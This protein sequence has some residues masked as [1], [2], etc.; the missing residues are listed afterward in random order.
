M[1][2]TNATRRS[3]HSIGS[4]AAAVA[5]GQLLSF[6]YPLVS[7]PLLARA[8][9]ADTLGRLIVIFAALQLLVRLTDYGFSVSAVRS[10]SLA[11]SEEERARTIS[12]TLAASVML[13]VAG[14]GT[15]SLVLLLTPSLRADFWLYFIG[16]VTISIGLGFPTWLLQGLRRLKLFALL[17]AGSRILALGGLVV[18]LH[19]PGDLAWAVLWQFAPM[20]IAALI[21]WPYL[22]TKVI[23]PV[24]PSLR[25]VWR[26]LADGRYPFYSSIA[27][28][29]MGSV[30]ALL[31]GIL[32]TPT[33][34]AYYGAGERFGN[35]GRGVLWAVSDAM[36]PRMADAATSQDESSRNQRRVIMGGLFLV[37]AMGGTTLI[38]VA[39]WFVPW[40]LG[41]GFESTVPVAR[42]IGVSLIVSGA[43]AVLALALNAEHRYT[44]T[45]KAIT[46]GAACHIVLLLF[47]TPQFGANGAAW[48]LVAS[49]L[50]VVLLLALPLW[51]RPRKS[52]HPNPSTTPRIGTAHA[53]YPQEA[54]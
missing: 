42:L 43:V 31:L 9:G 20:G 47:L 5:A 26:T 29:V 28:G 22:I 21:V 6:A 3:V 44:A 36:I 39:S 8:L 48:A 34:V 1:R 45:A 53:D 13:W 50:I 12:A 18:T 35:A 41:P 37:F 38:I 16:F 46:A 33:Q 19:G 17:T 11:S 54:A 24:V 49:E 52:T 7:L 51:R 4:D 25:L 40:Y 27:Q 2:L 23:R 15:T 32:S 30:P 10:I 14:A